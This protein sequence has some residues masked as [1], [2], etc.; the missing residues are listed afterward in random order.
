MGFGP[1]QGDSVAHGNFTIQAG[2][3]SSFYAPVTVANVNVTAVGNVGAGED[4]LITFSLPADVLSA[5]GKAVHITV[6]G[7]TA[8]NAAAKTLKVYFGTQIV[9]TNALTASIAGLWRV[10]AIVVRT[11]AATQD[12]HSQLVTLGVAAVALNDVEIGTATQDETTALTIKCTGEATSNN[13]I[14]Q[15]GLIVEL[16]N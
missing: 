6:W 4:D 2:A 10:E 13:D 15:E 5:N 14:L 3:S 11:G 16:L 7:S 12:W 9:L 8:N 1:A